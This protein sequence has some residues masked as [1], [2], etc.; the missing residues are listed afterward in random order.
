MKKIENGSVG[1]LLAA[2]APGPFMRA[3][4]ISLTGSGR[5]RVTCNWLYSSLNCDPNDDHTFLWEF[6]KIDGEHISLSPVDS[7]IERPIYASVRDDL[8]DYV[9][10]QAPFSA[11]WIT[12]VARD[13]TLAFEVHDLAIGQFNGFNGNYL[14]LDAHIDSHGGHAGYRVRSVGTTFD[15]ATQW[16]IRVHESLQAGIQFSGTDNGFD[17]LE[18]Q[19]G[20]GSISLGVDILNKLKKQLAT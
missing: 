4:L 3:E 2:S 17:A 12:A 10:V 1:S 11:D 13:E 6:S 18:Q 5:L 20:R 9:Q 14:Q 7:C 19:L 16:Y 8:D 15:A